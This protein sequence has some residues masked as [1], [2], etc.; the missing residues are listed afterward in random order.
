MT[1]ITRF[2]ELLF[3]DQPLD[4]LL[5]SAAET[6]FGE[7]PWTVL[8]E[9]GASIRDG[10]PD[11]AIQLLLK[12]TAKPDIQTRILLWSWTTLRGL[13]VLP[14]SAGA[15]EIKGIVI[16]VPVSG[17]IDVLAGYADGTARYINHSGKII[18]WDLPD[19]L[20]LDLIRKLLE[21]AGIL[22][23]PRLSNSAARST[24]EV[25]RV[26]L[27]TCGGNRTLYIPMQSLGSGPIKQLL[28][29]GGQL[30]ATLIKRTETM[31]QLISSSDESEF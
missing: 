15:S 3:A 10:K 20:V 11:E 12:I 28:S 13:G 8:S 26:T 29:R 7:G 23:A 19:A 2:K 18:V 14:D 9:A 25:V 30:M 24:S 17:G 21:C 27:L 4:Q 31:N 22:D 6:D 16:E 1:D 5:L